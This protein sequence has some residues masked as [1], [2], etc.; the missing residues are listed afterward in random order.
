MKNL[1][2]LITYKPTKLGGEN[3]WRGE[4][5]TYTAQV[6]GRFGNSEEGDKN[7]GLQCM[8]PEKGQRR[9]RYDQIMTLGWKILLPLSLANLLITG[10]VML[11]I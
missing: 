7:A 10:F 8:V 11:W 6:L 4:I 9:F 5:E 2:F 3:N 1:T